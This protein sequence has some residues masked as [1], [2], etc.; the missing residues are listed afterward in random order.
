MTAQG[1]REK[2]EADSRVEV[3]RVLADLSRLRFDA[4]QVDHVLRA[5]KLPVPAELTA[6][7]SGTYV[8]A[9][10]PQAPPAASEPAPAPPAEGVDIESPA[11]PS[12]E[13]V[14]RADE[15]KAKLADEVASSGSAVADPAAEPEVRVR[16]YLSLMPA[17]NGRPFAECKKPQQTSARAQMKILQFVNSRATTTAPDVEAANLGGIA[18]TAYNKH[19]NDLADAGLIV[20]TGKFRHGDAKQAKIDA[21]TL[22]GHPGR[23]AVEYGPKDKAA[24]PPPPATQVPPSE[25]VQDAQAERERITQAREKAA[26]DAMGPVRDMIVGL[27][28][29]F[30]PTQVAEATKLDLR[31]VKI[32]L[33]AMCD[34]KIVKNVS[35][36]KDLLLYQYVRPTDAGAAAT[37]DHA[38]SKAQANATT[39]NGGVPVAGTGKQ[40]TIS[41]AEVRTLVAQITKA[42]GTVTKASSGHFEVRNPATGQKVM[43]SSTPSNSRS[44]ANDRTRVRRIGLKV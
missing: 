23:M 18:P 15:R 3:E 4:T 1:F 9:E 13:A 35:P 44:V 40:L 14:K 2:I 38:A 17:L 41:N 22:G 43:I 16:S 20:R 29:P 21:G 33:A 31:Q 6:F 30:S 36:T 27:T 19:L 25:E 37:I 32:A 26:K 28:E 24:T 5:L 42:G 10:A 12:P 7:L 39:R 8:P 34:R 11:G